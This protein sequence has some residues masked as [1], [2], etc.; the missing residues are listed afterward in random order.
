VQYQKTSENY[1]NLT[2]LPPERGLGCATAVTVF[3]FLLL[4][5]SPAY[6]GKYALVIGNGSYSDAPLSTPVNDAD[7]MAATL[8]SLGFSVKKETD[9]SKPDMKKAIR[10]FGT[11]LSPGETALF[12]FSG[13]GAQAEGSNYLIPI[14]AD[15]QSEDEISDQSIPAEM[16]LEKMKTARSAVNIIILDACRNNPFKGFKSLKEGLAPIRVKL[17]IVSL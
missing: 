5:F 7:V 8:Q 6:A 4:S 17:S 14:G 16:V 13:H 1:E 15:I 10:D 11:R 9:I 2:A 3:L 12:Y